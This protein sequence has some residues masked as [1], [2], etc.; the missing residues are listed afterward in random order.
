MTT[1]PLA[2]LLTEAAELICSNPEFFRD[3]ENGPFV[4]NPDFER[5]N[6]ER[7]RYTAARALKVDRLEL[8]LFRE[9]DSWA[10]D[11]TEVVFMDWLDDDDFHQLRSGCRDALFDSFEARLTEWEKRG[12]LDAARETFAHWLGADYDLQAADVVLAAAAVEQ[13]DGD[14]VWLLIISGSGN[15]KTETVTAL[16]GAGA[17]VTSTIASEGALLS[18]TSK[19]ERAKDSTGGLLRK[20]GNRGLVVIK[21]FTTIISMNRDSRAAVLAALREIYDGRWERNVGTDGGRSLL[22]TGRIVVIGAVTTAYDAA[23]AVTASMGDR[24]ALVR[25]DSSKGRTASGRRALAN[26]GSEVEMRDELASV[27]ASV[28][29]RV[30]IDAARADRGRRRGAACR[31]RSRHPGPYGRRA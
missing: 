17:H 18:G 30:N 28:L 10:S 23:H 22:W 29:A 19:G 4:R 20:I 8:D 12:A 15:A 9:A 11:L 31:C 1:D 26:V 16:S 6:R 5:I 14:P 21:D 27:V 24:F 25:T 3:G 13:L 7:R 2:K